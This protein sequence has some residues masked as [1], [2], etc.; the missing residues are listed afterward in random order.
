MSYIVSFGVQRMEGSMV[1]HMFTYPVAVIIGVFVSQAVRQKPSKYPMLH[2]MAVLPWVVGGFYGPLGY[3]MFI[4]PYIGTLLIA[5]M[6]DWATV[7]GISMMLNAALIPLHSPLISL[8]LP[9]V[10]LFVYS[11]FHDVYHDTPY[12]LDV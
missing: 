8:I 2:I 11:W 1:H 3:P 7:A 12:N 9:I 10:V 4:L 6:C 5:N